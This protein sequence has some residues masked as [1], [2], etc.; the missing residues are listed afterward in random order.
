MTKQEQQLVDELHSR[1]CEMIQWFDA[2]C[3]KYNIE[4]YLACGSLIGAIRDKGFIPWDTD[5]DL[6]LTRSN[7]EKLCKHTDDFPEA[8]EMLY[9][10]SY[11]KNKYLDYE[12]HI[13]YKHSEFKAPPDVDAYYNHLAPAG[14][15]IDLFILDKT[16]NNL[17][18]KLQ[19]LELAFMF[20]LMNSHRIHTVNIDSY[21][22]YLKIF[23]N[24][25][26]IF[27]KHISLL[28]MLNKA[29]KISTR[30]NSCKDADYYVASN[31]GYAIR[32]IFPVK[33]FGRPIY[34]PFENLNAP[35]P[36]EADKILTKK[37]GDY[38]TPPPKNEQVPQIGVYDRSSIL[39]K[40]KAKK[41]TD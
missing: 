24:I 9:P 12:A 2:L 27:G 17:R 32:Q 4:Y 11:G 37:Y 16:Y 30:Y 39:K 7:Y 13:V 25:L 33:Q 18:G 1:G 26:K 41:E 31:D 23:G 5:I 15:H 3:N 35:I 38:M 6:W 29:D 19:R 36:V 20:G 28:W 22:W 10:T 14:M 21:P 8:F 34:V 40:V